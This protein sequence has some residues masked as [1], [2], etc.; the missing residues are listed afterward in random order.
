MET[1]EEI[2]KKQAEI[3]MQFNPV[4]EMYQLIDNYLP[5]GISDK[6]EQD[7]RSLLRKNWDQLIIQ[8]EG[9]RRL[10]QE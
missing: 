3:D 7:H 4:L 2:R 5:G 10:M 1:L 9:K 6:D 8:A